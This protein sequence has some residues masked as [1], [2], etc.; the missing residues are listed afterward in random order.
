MIESC[1]SAS[2][3]RAVSSVVIAYTIHNEQCLGESRSSY[4]LSEHLLAKLCL[5]DLGQ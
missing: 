2:G 4:Q 5:D 1:Q 3:P